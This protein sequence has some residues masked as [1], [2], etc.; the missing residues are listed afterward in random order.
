MDKG[1]GEVA[2]G[3]NCCKRE[4]TP[5]QAPLLVA[6]RRDPTQIR[7]VGGV[8]GIG[9]GHGVGGIG[10]LVGICR[11]ARVVGVRGAETYLEII[12]PLNKT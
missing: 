9:G 12:A 11:V 5:M 10:G 3:G 7:G 6:G 1:A 8:R 2:G 4:H